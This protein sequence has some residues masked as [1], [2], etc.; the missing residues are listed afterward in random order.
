MFSN[1]NNY[2]LDDIKDMINIFF[3]STNGLR[4]VI[5]VNKDMLIEDLIDKYLQKNRIFKE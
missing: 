5:W 2:N 3:D 4:T 1:F